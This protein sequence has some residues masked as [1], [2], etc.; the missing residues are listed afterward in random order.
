VLTAKSTVTF[1]HV[2]DDDEEEEDEDDDRYRKA[3][4]LDETSLI[5]GWMR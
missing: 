2:D 4:V 5:T 3:G 1:Q